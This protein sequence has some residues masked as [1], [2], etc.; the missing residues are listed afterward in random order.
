MRYGPLGPVEWPVKPYAT[1]PR[2]ITLMRIVGDTVHSQERRSSYAR[3]RP[4]SHSE[5]K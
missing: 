3:P 1:L 2:P 5:V 4:A